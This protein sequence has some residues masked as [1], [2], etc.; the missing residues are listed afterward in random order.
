VVED[1]KKQVDL[2]AD[3]EWV[4]KM[5]SKINN[6]LKNRMEEGEQSPVEDALLSKKPITVKCGSCNSLITHQRVEKAD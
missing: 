5:L 3:K 2:K 1:L 4:K 6:A